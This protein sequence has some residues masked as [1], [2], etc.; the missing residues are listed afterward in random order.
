MKTEIRTFVKVT[1]IKEDMVIVGESYKLQC[2]KR[3][4][5]NGGFEGLQWQTYDT[6]LEVLKVKVLDDGRIKLTLAS[7]AHVFT[8]KYDVN[9]I[10]EIK[11]GK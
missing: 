6:E 3:S 1:E 11:G 8:R 10:L 7:P 5:S 9:T 4:K 2:Q